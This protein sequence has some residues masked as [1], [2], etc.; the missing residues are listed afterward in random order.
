MSK[1]FLTENDRLENLK[2][3]GQLIKESFQKE[4]NKIKRLDEAELSDEELDA[5]A[6][7]DEEYENQATRANLKETMYNEMM[8]DALMVDVKCMT[9]IIM[10]M[11]FMNSVQPHLKQ[12]H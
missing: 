3:R 11:Q 6:K 12:H 10:V 4:F 8:L 5:L 1:K 9:Y 2:K 7:E